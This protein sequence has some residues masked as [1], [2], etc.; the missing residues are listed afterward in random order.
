MSA[1]FA[2]YEA[3]L[4]YY[5]SLKAEAEWFKRMSGLMSFASSHAP[6]RLRRDCHKLA[7]DLDDIHRGI[8]GDGFMCEY[9]LDA[10]P[11]LERLTQTCPAKELEGKGIAQFVTIHEPKVKKGTI[12]AEYL[13]QVE[14]NGEALKAL[15]DKGK[16]ASPEDDEMWCRLCKKLTTKAIVDR[17]AIM[18]CQECGLCQDYQREDMPGNITHTEQTEQT[19]IIQSFAYKRENHFSDWLNSLESFTTSEIP[20]AVY[21]AIRYE[22]KKRRITDLSTVTPQLVRQLLKKSRNNKYYEHTNL[23]CYTIIGQQPPGLE[24]ELKEQLRHMFSTIQ[25]PF[26]KHR[27]KR[28][29][30]L[31]YSYV[32]FKFLQLLERDDLL[33]NLSLLKSREKL[34]NQDQIWKLICSDLEW[35]FIKSL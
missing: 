11:Y 22:L 13:S 27:G 15:N 3:R 7:Q 30:F 28:K 31:S 17:E 19:T 8:V 5:A 14:K 4:D 6:L 16:V 33:K 23:I 29:N 25:K 10:L 9:I 21:D 24:D 18:V 1:F 26:D 2:V 35:Q 20:Q 32:L 34:H 12:F